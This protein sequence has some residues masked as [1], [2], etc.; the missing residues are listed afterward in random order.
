MW[1]VTLKKNNKKYALKEMSK[2]KIID[3][4]SE[5]SIKSERDFLSKLHHPFIVNMACSFQDYENLYLVMDLLTGGDLRY[6]L[7]H[8]EK[9]SEEE[10]KFFFACI[11]LGLEY[12]HK[13]N[14][15]HRDLK[16]ENLVCDENGYIRITDFGVAK[17]LKQENSSETSGTPGY[18]A[19]EVLFGLNHSFTAD[20]FALGVIGYEFMFGERP[21]IGKNRKEIKKLVIEKEAK[22]KFEDIQEGW[23]YESVDFINKCLKRS[24]KKRLGCNNGIIELKNHS[25]FKGFNWDKLYS[26]KKLAPF[27]PKRGGNY[28]KKYCEAI[29]KITEQTLERYQ[30]FKQQDN[31]KNIFNEYTFINYDMIPGIFIE[32]NSTKTTNTKTSKEINS[33]NNIERKYM[34]N[35]NFVKVEINEKRKLLMDKINNMKELKHHR[36]MLNINNIDSHLK[37]KDRK[38]LNQDNDNNIFTK[39]VYNNINNILNKIK[40]LASERNILKNTPYNSLIEISNSNLSNLKSNLSYTKNKNKNKRNTLTKI[41]TNYKYETRNNSNNGS[42]SNPNRNI[43]SFKLHKSNSFFANSILNKKENSVGKNNYTNLKLSNYIRLRRIEEEKKIK[44]DFPFL[45]KNSNLN[46]QKF[47][48]KMNLNLNQNNNYNLNSNNLNSR[49]KHFFSPTYAKM[50]KSQSDFFF[51]IPINNSNNTKNNLDINLGMNIEKIENYNLYNTFIQKKFR[52]YSKNS[53]PK[54]K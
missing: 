25:W 47:K 15:I 20:F 27:I 24:R 26:K 21:Y 16:P 42:L 43:L 7:C 53:A 32:T 41:Y 6:H 12:I 31:F 10:T 52:N 45:N 46:I 35:N 11:L 36:K 29:E 9:F 38:E 37:L 54:R 22:I 1:Q 5:K 49:N 50:K 39:S 17:I 8:Y 2:V 28:D 40:K 51:K 18:M 33:G 19:P 30:K 23:C 48:E 34:K 14:I 4:R 44:F 13:N 3:R